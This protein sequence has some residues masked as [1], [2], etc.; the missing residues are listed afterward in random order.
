MRMHAT[1]APAA[2]LAVERLA[3]QAGA[4]VRDVVVEQ[5]ALG[6][7]AV[8]IDL[9]VAAHVVVL[10]RRGQARG[11]VSLRTHVRS[12]PCV[13][14]CVR[15]LDMEKVDGL[16]RAV[17]GIDLAHIV[18][19]VGIVGQTLR[20]WV[21]ERSRCHVH[22]KCARRPY[23]QIGLKVLHIHGIEPHEGHKQTHVR[24]GEAVARQVPA[25]SGRPT[26]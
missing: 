25:L 16:V 4:V 14:V 13:C 3:G 8:R 24:L 21:C 5:R 11:L 6:H 10:C 19:Q 20:G 7:N 1:V 26:R 15:H 18:F 12:S 22:P 2:C 23:A 9:A 17:H